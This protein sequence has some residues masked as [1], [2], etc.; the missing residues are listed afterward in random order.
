MRSDLISAHPNRPNRRI[1]NTPRQES[2]DAAIS[3]ETEG[4]TEEAVQNPVQLTTEAMPPP[5]PTD[6]SARD[7]AAL[8]TAW[9]TLS[10]AV[11][12]SILALVR[13]QQ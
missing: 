6:E 3:A 12:A 10:P 8:V 1:E 2:N 9:P 11:R 5:N 13:S 4:F 7:L